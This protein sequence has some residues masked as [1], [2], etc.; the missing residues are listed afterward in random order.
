M[1]PEGHSFKDRA[2]TAAQC[3]WW[4]VHLALGYT[5]GDLEECLT[6]MKHESHPGEEDLLARLWQAKM[7]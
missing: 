6:G 2:Q 1:R 4:R 3:W 7:Q 5:L